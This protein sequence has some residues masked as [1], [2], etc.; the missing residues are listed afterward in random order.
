MDADAIVVGAGPAGSATALHLARRGHRVLIVDR[1]RFPRPKPCGE[2]LNPGAVEALR[3]LGVAGAVGRAGVSISGMFIAALD[4]QALWTPFPAGRGLLVPRERLDDL[5]R[6][7]AARAGAKVLEDCRVDAVIPGSPVVIEGRHAGEPIRLRGR[8]VIGA[9]GIRSV[10]A[11]R[12]GPLAPAAGGHY[13]VGAHFEGLAADSPRG[14]LHL[15]RG[16][17][18]GAALYGGG[19]GNVVVAMPRA[20]LQ[21]AGSDTEAAFRQACASL[22]LLGPLVRGARRVTPFASV[23]PLGYTRRSCVDDGVLL[24]GDAAGTIN[25][26]TGEGIALALR[27]AELAADAADRALRTGETSRRALAAYDRARR[28]AFGDVWRVSRLL[29]WIIR[30]PP[31]AA[32]L[33]RGL[34]RDPSLASRLLGVVGDVRPI[35]DVLNAGYLTR[36]IAHASFPS[37]P[38]R[39]AV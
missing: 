16:W 37:R 6:R 18:A 35:S 24:A 32:A 36:L 38:H 21:R 5:L 12:A 23:G 1:A 13:T 9:D 26:M 30:R 29:Q 4:G 3:R 2:Y 20:M 34:A 11:R 27:G 39:R 17:Y 31:M 7:A 28:A 14:D 25:P 8:L 15:G 22:P 33:F 19:R 10:V